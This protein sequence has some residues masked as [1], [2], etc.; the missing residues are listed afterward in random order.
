MLDEPT[1]GVSAEQVAEARFKI[2]IAYRLLDVFLMTKGAA[3]RKPTTCGPLVTHVRLP[4]DALNN[5]PATLKC[6][7][8]HILSH[9]DNVRGEADGH[10]EPELSTISGPRM[11]LYASLANCTTK[12]LTQNTLINLTS[13]ALHI[14]CL[15]KDALLNLGSHV[16]GLPKPSAITEAKRVIWTMLFSASKSGNILQDISLAIKSV[17]DLLAGSALDWVKVVQAPH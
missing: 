13:A 11:R 3:Q 8:K 6:F 1:S 17:E 5:L 9:I 7:H 10:T 2:L 12:R 4:L 16:A 14:A 15:L